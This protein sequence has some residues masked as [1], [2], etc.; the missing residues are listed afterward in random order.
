MEMIGLDLKTQEVT[1]HHKSP[2]GMIVAIPFCA[3]IGANVLI[4]PNASLGKN[5][6]IGDNS[7]IGVGAII[8]DDV[9]IGSDCR[10]ANCIIG[11]RAKI[12]NFVLGMKPGIVISDD[13]VVA[14]HSSIGCTDTELYSSK[15]ARCITSRCW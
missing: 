10:L 8:G 12:G 7:A 1:K 2:N 4:N 5:I 3:V 9:V 11:N 15:N 13:E 14:S 6:K